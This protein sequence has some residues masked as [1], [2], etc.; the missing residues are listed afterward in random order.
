MRAGV[1]AR[2]AY[3]AQP[4]LD[5]LRHGGDAGGVGHIGIEGR[6][7]P[8]SPAPPGRADRRAPGGRRRRRAGA[9]K[10]TSG[11]HSEAAGRKAAATIAGAKGQIH[12]PTP[13][14]GA[15]PSLQPTRGNRPT[16]GVIAPM[17]AHRV[18]S[19]PS[20]LRSIPSCVATGNGTGTGMR[21]AAGAAPARDMPRSWRGWLRQTA[22]AWTGDMNTG[23]T[24]SHGSPAGTAG[25]WGGWSSRRG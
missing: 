1:V 6:R 9:R 18:M 15:A 24:G 22:R 5:G 23:A 10:T 21:L 25:R 8:R 13:D 16:G 3:R 12:Q 11:T 14:I 2:D 7:L 4:R 19:V 17:V 20:C